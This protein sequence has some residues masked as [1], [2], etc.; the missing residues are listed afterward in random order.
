MAARTYI[1]QS[2]FGVSN[3]HWTFTGNTRQRPVMLPCPS[4][5]GNVAENDCNN[6]K[7]PITRGNRRVGRT[8]PIGHVPFHAGTLEYPDRKNRLEINGNFRV[9]NGTETGF[10]NHFLGKNPPN[11]PPLSE[12]DSRASPSLAAWFAGSVPSARW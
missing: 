3:S 10:Q 4:R 1:R 2:F 6:L 12:P 7:I 9:S 5:I 11:P 8:C